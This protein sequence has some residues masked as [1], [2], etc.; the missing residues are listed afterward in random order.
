MHE[1]ELPR[2][3]RT[4]LVCGG[5]G[6][7]GQREHD[8]EG[9]RRIYEHLEP[10]GTLVLDNEVPYADAYLWPYWS[11]EKRQE[12]PRPW[13][14]Q[15]D[16]RPVAD[17]TELELRSRLVEADPLAQRV[18]IEMR[19]FHWR[20]GELLAEEMHRIEMTLYFTHE[21]ELLLERAGFVD[22]EVRGA[23]RIVR[24]RRTTTS[25]SS[26]RESK[27]VLRP[28]AYATWLA[29]QAAESFATRLAWTVAPIY[30]VLEI[31]M[32]PLELVLA[33]TAFEVAY[34]LFEVPTGVVADTYGRRASVIVAQVVMGA[35]FIATGLVEGVLVILLAQAVI[36]FGWTFKSGAI[37]AWL[38]DEIGLERL[39]V[40]VSARSAGGQGRC[41]SSGSVQPS[42]WE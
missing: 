26:S 41:A 29:Y 21:L 15:G 40:G 3:Y 42:G 33:G 2:R 36:G 31:G 32:S 4:I 16:R 27:Y 11:K 10:G 35:G 13:R 37:D 39:G 19:A 9:L 14:D 5:F 17:G 7:G 24:R 22:I 20:G 34:F 23:L 6:L 28:S 18:A 38:A 30:F 25:W 12:L 8:I 1:L